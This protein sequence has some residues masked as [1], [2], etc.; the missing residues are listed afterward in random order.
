MNRVL[1]HL[2]F[3]SS[4]CQHIKRS[5]KTLFVS[6]IKSSHVWVGC[7][8]KCECCMS[9]PFIYYAY[10]FSVNVPMKLTYMNLIFSLTWPAVLVICLFIFFGS[11]H[12]QVNDH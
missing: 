1:D 12:N 5:I 11:L 9:K 8:N 10:S 4:C 3:T 2:V 7:V 6:F